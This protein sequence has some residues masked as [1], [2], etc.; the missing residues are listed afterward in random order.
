MSLNYKEID[1]VL[2]E[3]DIENAFIQQIVQPGYD[4][5]A[6]YVYKTSYQNAKVLYICLAAGEC[7]IH[8]TKR[9]IPKTA[10][11]LRFM[12]FLK[13]RVKGCKIA[14][15]R[16]IGKERIVR[17]ELER[18][19][20]KYHMFIKLWS[21]AANVLLTDENLCILDAFY[22]RPKRKEVS[23]GI[24]TL[25]EIDG[26]HI[27]AAQKTFEIRN[28]DELLA[29]EKIDSTD[30]SLNEKIDLWYGEHGERCSRSAL[31]LQ[32][33]KK[34]GQAV[35]RIQGALQ[36]LEEKRKDFENAALW[37][38]QGDLILAHAHLLNAQKNRESEKTAESSA[39]NSIPKN[40]AAGKKMVGDK[41][42]TGEGKHS[43][44]SSIECT[45][46][47][48]G[49]SIV[50]LKIDPL[51]SAAQ[52]AQM[53]YTKYKKAASGS[54]E[55]PV[56]AAL[57]Y[58]L[59]ERLTEYFQNKKTSA[60]QSAEAISGTGKYPVS[61][62]R[63]N[64]VKSK[65]GIKKAL[66]QCAAQ[67]Q[68]ELQNPLLDDT[69]ENTAKTSKNSAALLVRT[70]KN[71]YT[72][73]ASASMQTLLSRARLISQGIE[74]NGNPALYIDRLNSLEQADEQQM[75]SV[76]QKYFVFLSGKN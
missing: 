38:H 54:A 59:A 32:A 21:G 46:Y 9:N 19:G 68:S 62:L 33:E 44:T 5:L 41:K 28:F 43:G 12:E 42:K 49:G 71:R 72:G 56:F 27:R 73:I 64:K 11:P 55:E 7:R 76:F 8:E 20:E 47:E 51:K 15:C 53:Y 35:N 6:L 40:S 29:T 17:L 34:Y 30:L 50:C 22:R 57:L 26:E 2:A 24:F 69:N 75:A 48:N 66:A 74:D 39:N 3:L 45:D 67:L 36:R 23:G 52:N 65:E 37:K 10:K 16:Q 63:F 61:S 60:A 70:I 58:E 1:A 25:P 4:S 18:S 13:S 31:L 14:S